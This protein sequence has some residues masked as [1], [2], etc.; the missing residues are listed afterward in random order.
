MLW[1][2]E[3]FKRKRAH[4]KAIKLKKNIRFVHKNNK[5]IKSSLDIDP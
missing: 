3:K 2:H 4:D 5:N 1:I